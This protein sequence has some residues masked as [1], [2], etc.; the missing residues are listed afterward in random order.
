[1]KS[2]CFPLSKNNHKFKSYAKMATREQR[3]AN[4]IVVQNMQW[5][6]KV[7]YE[8]W[9]LIIYTPWGPLLAS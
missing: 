9:G 1:M 4:N 3:K 5:F 8:G 6:Q 2:D 7:P